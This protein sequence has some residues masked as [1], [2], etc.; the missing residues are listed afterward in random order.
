MRVYARQANNR[1]LEVEAT[2]IR[3]RA[4]RWLGELIKAQKETVGLNPRAAG[5]AGPGRGKKRG[6]KKEPRFTAHPSRD[7]H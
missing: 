1:E 2:E 6:A 7:Q 3:I 4:E 5:A